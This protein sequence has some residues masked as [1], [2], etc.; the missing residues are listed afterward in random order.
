MNHHDALAALSSAAG[1][2]K[3]TRSQQANACVEVTDQVPG[4]IGV[5]DSKLGARSPLLAFPEIEWTAMLAAA[6]NGEFDL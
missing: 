3:S 4:W 2:R 5:R 1:W 6:R